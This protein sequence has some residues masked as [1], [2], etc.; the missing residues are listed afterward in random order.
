MGNRIID[1]G[2]QTRMHDTCQAYMRSLTHGVSKIDA[3]TEL[4]DNAMDAGKKVDV[5]YDRPNHKFYVFNDTKP[6]P[7]THLRSL[8]NNAEFHGK[9]GENV[10]SNYG[11]GFKKGVGSLINYQSRDSHVV[12]ITCDGKTEPYG[13]TWDILKNFV[14]ET[15]TCH[16]EMSFEDYNLTPFVGT[17]VI[18]DNVNISHFEEEMLKTELAIIYSRRTFGRSILTYNGEI[19]RP[20]DPMYGY[21]LGD[22]I[23]R[24]GVNDYFINNK[25][26]RVVNVE[27][28]H[29]NDKNIYF[30]IRLI[31]MFIPLLTYNSPNRADYIHECENNELYQGG[32]YVLYSDR[33]ITRGNGNFI[34][35]LGAGKPQSGGGRMRNSVEFNKSGANVFH[36]HPTKNQGV[37]SLLTNED[38]DDYLI[39][40]DGKKKPI[41]LKQYICKNMWTWINKMRSHIDNGDFEDVGEITEEMIRAWGKTTRTKKLIT[42]SDLKKK[43]NVDIDLDAIDKCKNRSINTTELGMCR[44][45]SDFKGEVLNDEIINKIIDTFVND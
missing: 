16:E 41:N 24:A 30:P 45:L 3:V 6:F 20:Y 4:V 1:F 32:E 34:E 18:I 9:K 23:N 25:V 38:L 37:P 39:K 10:I 5:Y 28:Y 2:V 35:M 27:A 11:V 43:S 40:I 14:D 31:G 13:L 33:Y 22:R 42:P 7:I 12:V 19:I 8:L 26:F 44:V 29:K 21:E 36:V 15:S 17:C